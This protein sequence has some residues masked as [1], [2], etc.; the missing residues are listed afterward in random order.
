MIFDSGLEDESKIVTYVATDNY[1]GGVLA[2]RRM[3]EVLHGKGNVILLRYFPGSESTEQREQGFLDDAAERV[4]R[5]SRS[6]RPTSTRAPLP[7]N[8]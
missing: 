1:K 8:R 5:R 6:S 2:A 3:A 7:R 4:S